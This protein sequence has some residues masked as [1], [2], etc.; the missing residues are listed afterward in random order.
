MQQKHTT[1]LRK[2]KEAQDNLTQENLQKMLWTEIEIRIRQ[3]IK[4]IIEEFLEAELD[5][6]LKARKYERTDK[7]KDY[8]NGSYT[9]SLGTIYGEIGD[10]AVPRLRN[11][12]ID[13]EIFD[14]YARR[15]GS[16]D[17]AI[18]TLFLNGVS[19]RKLKG[20]ARTYFNVPLSPSTAS[21]VS[22]KLS[23]KDL[24]S[25]QQK[26]L[27]D[28]YQFVFLDGISAKTRKVKVE[29]DM[30]LCTIGITYDGRKEILG[31]R[32]VE[33]ESEADWEAFLVDLK[34]RGLSGKKI[35][36][37]TTDGNAGLIKALKR[38][39]PFIKRQR[40]IA[41][42]SRNI[43]SKLRRAN[44]KACMAGVKAVFNSK[45]K[46]EAIRRFKEWKSYWEIAE[47]SAVRCLEKDLYDCLTF[48]DFKEHH[49][50]KIRT[51]N[52]I[53]RTFREVRRRTRPMSIALEPESTE[54]L[55]A[56]IAGGLNENWKKQHEHQITK[57]S[58]D[59]FTQKS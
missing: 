17:E 40:C 55:F 10:L 25:F 42:K 41:H 51:T 9:R 2:C 57:K 27:F 43:A 53:E 3:Y 35:Q 46:R 58:L 32:L 56:G 13:Y 22:Q 18:G 59:E 44:Q 45:S 5:N 21:A 38:I 31:A 14:R 12:K 48:Y 23:Q 11:G 6:F 15:A 19:T 29:R 50:K 7:R 20:I 39:Y 34:S 47:E 4:S 49:W 30:I 54:R 16:V 52:I 37:I 1:S 28:K 24:E 8:R 36:L 33:G 26:K